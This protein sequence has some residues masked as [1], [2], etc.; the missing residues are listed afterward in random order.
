MDMKKMCKVAQVLEG[1]PIGEIDGICVCDIPLFKYA[2]LTS[3]DVERSFSQYKSLFRDNGHAFVMEN[4]EMT[5]A[6]H[7]NSRT[8]TSN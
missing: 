8:T 7:C 6:V 4:L 5:F 3:C 2:R 1:V